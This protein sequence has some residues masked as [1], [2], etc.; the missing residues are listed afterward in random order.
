M[1]Y[2]A[3]ISISLS[4]NTEKDDIWLAFR[5]IF[6][7]WK[8][9]NGKEIKTLEESLKNYL[10][11]KSVFSFNSGRSSFFAILKSLDLPTDSEVLLQ[12]FTCN[13][14]V[15]PVIWAGLNP[16]YVDCDK[17]TYNMSLSE[18]KTKITAKSKV[19]LV[20]HTF[21]LP[22]D[23]DEILKIANENNLIVIED[24][25]HALGALYKGKKVGTFG[26]AAFYS[27]SR[28]KVISSVYG[29][30]VA[31]NDSRLAENLAKF[32]E[33]IGFPKPF[34]ALQQLAHPVLLN[35][36]ILPIYKFFD[37]GKIFL[38][39][40]QITHILSKA[41]RMEEKRGEMPNYFPK[42]LPNSLAILADKQLFKL[43]K[44]YNHR[45]KLSNI[46]FKELENSGFKV[47]KFVS[48]N[49]LREHGLRHSFLRFTVNH[50]KAFEII[51]TAWDKENILIGDWYTSPVAPDDTK[52]DKLKY[53]VG[54]CPVAES[55]A[56]RT[57]NLPTHINISRSDA[58][59][60]VG[61]LKK[62]AK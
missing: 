21:G 43:D 51:H 35:T 37:L 61:F 45:E 58:M 46:Y 27:F 41:V 18:L 44:F 62:I 59:R 52:L 15:N 26:L 17:E 4:P 8:W 7:P 22:A 9:N 40:S 34:W 11:V 28:D 32:Q 10:G 55:L 38:V 1:K 23:M 42:K 36:I 5:L 47:S 13:A 56:K 49:Y 6:C 24:C 20:Q 30:A 12:A 33:Q 19:L 2:F 29:G 31:T 50:D 25:A 14:A 57:I 16:I 39:L 54:S 48:P 60:V 53:A 3:P